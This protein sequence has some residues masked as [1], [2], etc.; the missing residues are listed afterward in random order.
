MELLDLS[1]L[2]GVLIFVGGAILLIFVAYV[3]LRALLV[4]RRV[5]MDRQTPQYW[6]HR[7]NSEGP[8]GLI[9]RKIPDRVPKLSPEQ[10][11]R[12][13]VVVEEG[14]TPPIHGVVSWRLKDLVQRVLAA[15]E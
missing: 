6:V 4:A 2:F 10:K 3:V 11:A 13:A 5:G 9:D 12:L 7:F 1:N 8:E 14:P 15:I